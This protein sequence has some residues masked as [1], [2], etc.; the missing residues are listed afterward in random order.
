MK[1]YIHIKGGASR[2]M[3]T[4]S[5]LIRKSEWL[6]KIKIDHSTDIINDADKSIKDISENTKEE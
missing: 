1:Y 3:P 5:S 4:Y 6:N 2:E